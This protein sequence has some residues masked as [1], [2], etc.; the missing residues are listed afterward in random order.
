MAD[1]CCQHPH[2]NI[3]VPL[4]L[5]VTA[6]DE[7]VSVLAPLCDES[8]FDNGKRTPAPDMLLR[9]PLD[10]RYGTDWSRLTSDIGLVR[11]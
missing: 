3:L 1:F 10:A 6:T 2:R 7:I 4:A 5:I 9:R 8:L 11:Q